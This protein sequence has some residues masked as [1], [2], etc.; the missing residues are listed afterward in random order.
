MIG[1]YFTIKNT[2]MRIKEIEIK[3]LFDMFDHSIKLNDKEHLTIIYGING[4]GKTMLFKI[5]DS[6]F[7]RKFSKL[8]NYP[9][10]Q[11]K[12]YYDNG[13]YFN[14]K[15]NKSSFIIEYYHD[16]LNEKYDIDQYKTIDEKFKR[17]ISRHLSVERIGEDEYLVPSTNKIL[18]T[19]EVINRF[20][21][22][23]PDYTLKKP[24]QEELKKI[25]S[26][27]NLYFI[28]TQRLIKFESNIFQDI[29]GEYESHKT[30]TVK[31]YSEELSQL[32]QSKHSE[33]AKLSEKLELSLGRRLINRKVQPFSSNTELK[34]ENK[35]LEEKR[36]RL[37]SVGLFE[38]IKDEQ[39]AI[40]NEIDD[41]TR[42]ILSVNIKDMKEK[43][44]I[45]DEF[46]D[47]LNI[48]LDI[49]NNKR[50]SYKKISIHP[51]KGFVFTNDNGKELKVTELSSGEQHE[52]VLLYELLFKVPENSLVL[53]DEPEISLHVAWQKE[54]LDDMAEVV[55][56]RNFDIL[57]A[58]HSPSII[59]D[60]W[61]LTVELE[62]N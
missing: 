32:I 60:N 8:V 33:Y 42:A 26:Q 36:S 19:E 13:I 23:L 54:F 49:L 4:I 15:N 12:I 6:F 5:L 46:Y 44:K 62:K 28:E 18:S 37:K 38:D 39:F 31:N 53:I 29:S 25:I 51:K 34:E 27:T 47:R 11:L 22:I 55:K 41:T 45:F 1:K 20:S 7:N 3:G 14:I 10:K 48:F 40:P 61:H 21:D 43:L 35:K 2:K 24:K 52:I 16:E 57:I 50:F 17:E 30:E 58:T 9:F 59:D 56:I